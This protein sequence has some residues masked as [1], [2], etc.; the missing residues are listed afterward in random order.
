MTHSRGDDVGGG[1][2]VSAAGA[3]AGGGSGKRCIDDFSVE[4]VCALVHSIGFPDAAEA[5]RENMVDG[6][7]LASDDFDEALG[8]SVAE[9]GLGLTF[10]Q[11][12]R[13]RKEIKARR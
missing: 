8:M 10:M 2:A 5:L 3:I 12:M 13:L 7:T 4:E 1:T 6:E 9:G 11:K